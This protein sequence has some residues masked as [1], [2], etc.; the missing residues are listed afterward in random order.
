MRRNAQINYIHTFNSNLL[1]TLGFGY[2]R[3]NNQS[4]PLNYGQAVNTAFGQPNVNLDQNTSGL[5]PVF[6]AE[7][8]RISAMATSFRSKTS[9]TPSSIRAP[10]RSTG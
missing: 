4:L 10:S 3:I 1:L 7:T 8:S 6:C 9:T 2:T 5:A